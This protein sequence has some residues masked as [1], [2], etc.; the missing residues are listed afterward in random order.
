M[1]ERRPAWLDNTKNRNGVAPPWPP[2]FGVYFERIFR[3]DCGEQ[4]IDVHDSDCNDRCPACN[5]EVEPRE[6]HERDALS[7]DYAQDR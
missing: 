4:W 2:E 3:C 6:T 7:G 5:R 1:A